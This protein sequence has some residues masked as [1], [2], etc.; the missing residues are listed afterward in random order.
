MP[1]EI[2]FYFDFVSPYSYLAST[3]LPRF[4]AERGAILNYR[5][6]ALLDLMKIVGNRP[7]TL[8][9]KNKGAYAMADL[10]RWA[11]N[12]QVSFAPSPF[13]HGVDFAELGRGMLVALDEGRGADYVAAIYPAVFGKPVDLGQRAELARVLDS[14]GFDAARL[15]ER[16]GSA[17]YV[18]RLEKNTTAAAERGV[19]GSPT[20]F[21]GGEMFFGND[22]LDF[23][24][25]ALRAAA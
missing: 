10:Q 16:A 15:L 17:E 19:F 24:S 13:W 4:A 6:F 8:E 22:R 9:C 23:M 20:M 11:K 5:P 18:A 7:T 12:Y 21:V 1:A 2:D 3:V 25:E 14:A